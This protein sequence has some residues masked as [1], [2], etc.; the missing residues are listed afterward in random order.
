MNLL[1]FFLNLL[2][3][4]FFI[5]LVINIFDCYKKF[6]SKSVIWQILQIPVNNGFLECLKNTLD[7]TSNGDSTKDIID[8]KL[9]AYIFINGLVLEKDNCHKIGDKLMLNLI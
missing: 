2:S 7:N 8:L 6:F 5:T 9:K 4:V 1:I 3:F